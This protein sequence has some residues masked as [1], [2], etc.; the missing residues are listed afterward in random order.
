MLYE[1]IN[2]DPTRRNKRSGFFGGANLD[3]IKR[4]EEL[5]NKV[6]QLSEKRATT[7]SF[8]LAKTSSATDVTD[9]SSGTVLSAIQNNAGIK[10]T[11][12]NK[13]G[14]IDKKFGEQQFLDITN[15]IS[16]PI[17]SSDGN[18]VI[19]CGNIV[20]LRLAVMLQN[21]L[22]QG[23]VWANIP[24]GFRTA[25][26]LKVPIARYYGGKCLSGAVSLER[27]GT[28]FTDLGGYADEWV[29]LYTSYY[30]S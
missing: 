17:K 19:R 30:A 12:A 8:G 14:E 26:Y 13:I 27:N 4:I 5:E 2:H 6:D 9:E 22:E 11:L 25:Q 29:F 10:G 28:V 20:F 24:E 1:L 23:K 18:F 21:N 16:V 3:F 15:R 7:E